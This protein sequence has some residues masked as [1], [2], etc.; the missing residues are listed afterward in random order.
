MRFENITKHYR[1]GWPALDHLDL[2]ID[3]GEVFSFV[4]PSGCGKTTALRI[5]AGLEAPT[6]GRIHLDG[7]DITKVKTQDRRFGMVTQQNQLM[8]HMSAGKN[9]SFPMEVQDQ[10][11]GGMLPE[12]VHEEAEHFGIVDL[13]DHRPATLSEGQRRLVQLARAVIS[14]PSTLLMDEPLANLEDQVRHRLRR[15]ILQVHHDRSLTTVIATASQHDAMA[16]SDRIAVL[17]GG[18]IDQVGTPHEIFER[19]ATARVA[20]FFGE[21]AMNLVTSRVRSDAGSRIVDVLGVRL[22]MWTRLLEPY[23]GSEV[24]V[25]VRPGDFQ[26]GAALDRSIS[27]RV[28][29]TEPLGHESIVGVETAAGHPM[30][31]VVKGRPPRVGTTLDLGLAADRLHLFDPATGLA[32]HHPV[33]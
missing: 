5:L 33:G 17:F 11:F 8:N 26:L 16:M 23:V 21:P 4:G 6:S 15:E 30:R 14:S 22:R 24:T 31:C 9:I 20:A 10:Y 28:T 18:L 1:D 13:L 2:S 19:P 32:I 12:K 29:S 3:A 27:G 7:V 25:G